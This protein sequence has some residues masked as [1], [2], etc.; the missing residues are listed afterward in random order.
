VLRQLCF[1]ADELDDRA[2]AA[3]RGLP[4]LGAAGGRPPRRARR[5][6][7]GSWPF[8]GRFR[9]GQRDLAEAVYRTAARAAACWRRR[10]PASARPWA[11][12]PAA[13]GHAGQGIDKLAYLTCK[14]TGR[15]TALEAL[16]D[17]RA[18]TPGQALRVLVMVP[19]DEAASTPTRPATATPARWPRGFYD[20]LPAARQEAVAQGWLDAA[21]QRRIA[22]R[23]GICPYYLGQELV[24]WAD[25]LVGDVHHLFDA[26]GLLWGLMQALDW[27]LAVLV[28][29][30]HNLVERARRMYSTELPSSCS[31]SRSWSKR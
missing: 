10:P 2:G 16:G 22:L 24:R 17:L 13:A 27:K 3:L 8:R 1:G 14:G 7:A 20:R 28:D 25:V 5:G 26:S 29:E 18:G 9:A 11:P 21:A 23:H 30:A 15:L 6:A 31:D 19:K 4:G 12:V